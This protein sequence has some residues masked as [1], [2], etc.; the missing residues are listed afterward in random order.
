MVGRKVRD[1]MM[2]EERKAKG[3]RRKGM[4][5]QVV[6]MQEKGKVWSSTRGQRLTQFYNVHGGVSFP[7]VAA[8]LLPLVP[9]LL[10][11][12]ALTLQTLQTLQTFRG[13][14]SP[15]VIRLQVRVVLP[16]CHGPWPTG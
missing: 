1:M 5:C 9:C 13:K 4:K 3:E 10:P 8:R 6:Q 7:G 14:Q 11:L 12:R 2:S 15:K 16:V